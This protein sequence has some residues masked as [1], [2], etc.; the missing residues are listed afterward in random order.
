MIVLLCQTFGQYIVKSY[1]S[2]TDRKSH[3]GVGCSTKTRP[4]KTK[5]R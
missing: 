5:L 2:G 4:L 3:I 1:F